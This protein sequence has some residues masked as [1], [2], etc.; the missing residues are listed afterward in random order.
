MFSNKAQNAF[1]IE[2]NYVAYRVAKKLP[3]DHLTGYQTIQFFSRIL[4]L[5]VDNCT[6]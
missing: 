3:C 4:K 2:N 6:L 5:S 1:K